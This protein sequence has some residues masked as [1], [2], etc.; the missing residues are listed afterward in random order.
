MKISLCDL[1]EIIQKL[2]TLNKKIE[3]FDLRL[4]NMKESR[5]RAWEEAKKWQGK[6]S[7]IKEENNALRKLVS[8]QFRKTNDQNN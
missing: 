4:K 5:N 1:D 2:N 8:K 7:I 6:Y 3:K